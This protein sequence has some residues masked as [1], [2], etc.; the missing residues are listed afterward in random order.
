MPSTGRS[1][2]PA[3]ALAGAMLL[4]LLP[5]AGWTAAP[6]AGQPPDACADLESCRTAALEAEAA[7]D[8]E[9]FHDLAWRVMQLAPKDDAAA[10][11]VVARAQAA[12]GRSSDALVMLRRLAEAGVATD[13]A[14][15][16]VFARVRQ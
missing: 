15:L 8:G 7:G 9:R 11:Y 1:R 14:D 4:V 5:Q 16:D 6:G 3:M 10:M 2:L 13:A 12:S